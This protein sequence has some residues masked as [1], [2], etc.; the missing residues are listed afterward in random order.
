MT[1]SWINLWIAIAMSLA[2]QTLLKAGAV[3]HQVSTALL[4]NSWTADGCG[5]DLIRWR[6]VPLHYRIAPHSALRRATLH[7]SLL[8]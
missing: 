8:Y 6:R 2:G 4:R 1:L 5:S 7:G 3:T